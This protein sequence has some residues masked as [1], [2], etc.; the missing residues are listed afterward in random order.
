M[1]N[2]EGLSELRYLDNNNYHKVLSVD[3]TNSFLT[4]IPEKIFLL[5]NIKILILNNNFIT[6]ITDKIS[7]LKYLEE[8]YLHKN[9]ITDISNEIGKLKKLKKIILSNNKIKIL[10]KG[11]YN[12]S[13]LE[14]LNLSSNELEIITDDIKKLKKLEY[15]FLRLNKLKYISKKLKNIIHVHIFP[16]SFEN[17]DNLSDELEYLQINKLTEPINNLPINIKEIRLFLPL[18]V[19]IKLP[20]NCKLYIDDILQTN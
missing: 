14:I 19:N 17:F 10:P 1:I 20:F 15:L 12:L 3:L 16:D 13:K 7:N 6:N 11:F 8:L 9:N 2:I 4:E 18:K 5:S